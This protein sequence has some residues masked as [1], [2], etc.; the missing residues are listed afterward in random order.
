MTTLPSIASQLTY[1]A[2][3]GIGSTLG[4]A[5]LPGLLGWPIARVGGH[6]LLG[7]A[8]FLVVG[9][10]SAAFGLSWGQT[11]VSRLF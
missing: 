4:M 3:F 8:I 2:L 9:C 5:V 6:R 7:R 1:M 10:T 11:I